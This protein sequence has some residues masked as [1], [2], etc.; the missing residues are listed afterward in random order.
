[1]GCG[2]RPSY[3]RWTYALGGLSHVLVCQARPLGPQHTPMV[4]SLKTR[5][6]KVG[7]APWEL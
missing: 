5:S 1:M 2:A 3:M 6:G 4:S 7:G